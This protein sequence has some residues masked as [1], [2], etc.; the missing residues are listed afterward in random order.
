MPPDDDYFDR[1]PKMRP[2]PGASGYDRD[3]ARAEQDRGSDG[4]ASLAY[5]ILRA[6][7]ELYRLMRR[8]KSTDPRGG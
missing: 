8:R 6:V 1:G 5:W 2:Q 3:L 4:L 7:Q